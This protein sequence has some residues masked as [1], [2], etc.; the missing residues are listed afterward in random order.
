[1][2]IPYQNLCFVFFAHKKTNGT[3]IKIL[4]KIYGFFNAQ[5]KWEIH[6]NPLSKSLMFFCT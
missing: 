4:I 1:M 6:G 2:E 3:S 5:K